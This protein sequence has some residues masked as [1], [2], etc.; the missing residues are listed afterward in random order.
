MKDTARRHQVIR[1][2]QKDKMLGLFADFLYI[3]VLY[4]EASLVAQ[5]VKHLPAMQKTRFDPW[6]GKILWRREW[7][8]TPVFLPG[9][10]HGPRSLAGYSPWG[11][12]ELD[13]TE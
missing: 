6:V 7:Q 10:S 3:T 4:F 1:G 12:E 5:M 8:L 11:H 9:E 2:R 13:T